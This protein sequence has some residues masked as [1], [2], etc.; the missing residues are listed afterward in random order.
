MRNP[1]L[2]ALA[3]TINKQGGTLLASIEEPLA[4][5]RRSASAP[6]SKDG[7]PPPR[8]HRCTTSPV[9]ASIFTCIV[10]S[11]TLGMLLFQLLYQTAE[12]AMLQ[13]ST[14]GGMEFLS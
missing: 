11:A 9:H 10:P 4:M 3:S 1:S 13:M 12:D 5:S 8:L 6:A 14:Q 2:A 7:G